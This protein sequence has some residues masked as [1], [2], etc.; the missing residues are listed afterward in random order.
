MIVNVMSRYFSPD[1]WSDLVF[2]KFLFAPVYYDSICS[3]SNGALMEVDVVA[4]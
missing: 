3:I 2:S 4:D 1:G